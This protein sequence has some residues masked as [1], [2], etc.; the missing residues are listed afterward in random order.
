MNNQSVWSP[1]QYDS[2][3]NNVRTE[4]FDNIYPSWEIR[5]AELSKHPDQYGRFIE[6]LKRKQAIDT[7]II[8]RLYDLKKGVTE[9]FIEKGF[10]DSY[11]QHGDTDIAPDLLMHYL[12]DNF[13]AIDFIFDF[14]KNDRT[15]S[16]GFIK[17]L[18]SLITQHQDTTDAIDQFGY[19]VKV[20]LLKGQFKVNPNNPQKNGVIYEYCPPVQV[21]SEMD[22]LIYIFNKD[23]LDAHVLVKSAFLHHAFSQIHPFQDGNGR[24]ARLLASFILIKAGLFPLSI[25][26]DDR[27][28]YID[29]LESADKRKYQPLVEVFAD[30]QISSI[31]RSLN[32]KTVEYSAGYGNVLD[33]FD[34]K[35]ADYRATEAERRNKRV[36]SNMAN[37]FEEIKRQ[38]E[39]IKD[40]MTHRFDSATVIDL[41]FCVPGGTTDYYYN[42]QIIDYA[43]LNNYYV[44]LSLGKCWV[45]VFLKIDSTKKYRILLSL[46]HYGYDNSAFAIGAFLSRAI[47][48]IEGNRSKDAPS[49][50]S[51]YTDISLGIPPL[52]ISSTKD[53]S[54]MISSIKQ[55]VEISIMAALAYIAN[56]LG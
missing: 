11:L 32:W 35:L 41:S 48:D 17:E 49:S 29:A 40:D 38:M 12:R 2:E 28:K 7:G 6:Q 42:K 15:L 34:K 16:V 43:S 25:D 56:E 21:D 50:G 33:V 51:K 26:R 10:V 53:V 18:H 13:E 27:S 30:N 5:R 19:C 47:P 22:S 1:I 55:Q 52:T 20:P 45:G 36:I 8:E 9:T 14:V 3:W 24:I 23:F 4:R 31:E 44:N 37:I 46:H 39:K 54:E